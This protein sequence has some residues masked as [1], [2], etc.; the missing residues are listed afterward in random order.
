MYLGAA[1]LL[2][3]LLDLHARLVDVVDEHDALHE[4]TV[5]GATALADICT[6]VSVAYPYTL[7]YSLL[8]GPVYRSTSTKHANKFKIGY[9]RITT[10]V[11]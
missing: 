3:E 11:A 2:E 5:R 7:Q 4:Q 1:H 8:T 10:D 6:S 9:I